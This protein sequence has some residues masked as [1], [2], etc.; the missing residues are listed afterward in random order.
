L[1]GHLISEGIDTL[2]VCG[3][4]VSGC[5]RATVTDGCSN[6]LHMVV[7]EECVYDRHEASRAINLF[8]IDQKYGDVITLEEATTWMAQYRPTMATSDPTL[9]ET[10]S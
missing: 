1:L 6:R 2:I 9:A 5:V 7:V 4:S 8:D 10:N 3:E